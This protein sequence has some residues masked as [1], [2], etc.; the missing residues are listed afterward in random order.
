MTFAAFVPAVLA[1]LL[2]P[3]PTNMLMA[4]AGAEA[5]IRRVAWLI[6]VAVMG[7][8]VALLP[9]VTLGAGLL[10][11]W[12]LLAAGVKGAAGVWVLLL[13]I[14]LWAPGGSSG[15]GG[16]ITARAVFVTTLLNP[17]VLIFGLVL[18]P[19]VRAA[20][21]AAKGALFILMVVGAT[22]LWGAGGTLSQ[23]GQGGAGRLRLVQRIASLWLAI[24]S[25]ALLLGALRP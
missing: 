14:R 21:F 25:V 9:F 7:Y 19:G 11:Q 13:A 5:G 23:A 8:A 4:L 6:P 3:G 18:L 2:A 17:K 24:V 16:P 15:Q 1:L 22:L 20:D 10:G 12:P